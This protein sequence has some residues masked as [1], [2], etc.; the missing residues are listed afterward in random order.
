MG[1]TIRRLGAFAIMVLFVMVMVIPVVSVNVAFETWLVTLILVAVVVPIVLWF[2]LGWSRKK[3]EEKGT[4]LLIWRG[5]TEDEW[6]EEMDPDDFEG[7][8][9]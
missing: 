6:K 9:D 3:K 2:S 4:E 8:V 1:D 5:Y 7:E